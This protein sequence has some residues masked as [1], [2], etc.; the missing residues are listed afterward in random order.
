[1]QNNTL[2]EFAVCSQACLKLRESLKVEGKTARRKKTDEI[3]VKPV[4]KD[5]AMMVNIVKS[6]RS[7]GCLRDI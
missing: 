4:E 3:K 1:M 6:V 2:A 5:H 7:Y